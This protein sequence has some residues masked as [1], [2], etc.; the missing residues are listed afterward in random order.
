MLHAAPPELPDTARLKR[1]LLLLVVIVLLID[2]VF[3]L[4]YRFTP[5]HSASGTLKQGYTAL[6][7]PGAR[8]SRRV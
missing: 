1:E 8:G 7:A 4:L 3:I 6:V 5:L 2:G